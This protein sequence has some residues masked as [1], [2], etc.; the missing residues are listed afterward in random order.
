MVEASKKIPGITDLEAR[1]VESRQ[2]ALLAYLLDVGE[3]TEEDRIPILECLSQNTSDSGI[4]VWSAKKGKSFQIKKLSDEEEG[5]KQ[6]SMKHRALLSILTKTTAGQCKQLPGH[7][8][9]LFILYP[10][11]CLP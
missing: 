10:V 4:L 3:V 1:I 9:K 5:G 2:S 8:N 6:S 7:E 11:F